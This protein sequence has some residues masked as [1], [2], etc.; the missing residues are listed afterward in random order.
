MVVQNY[1][2]GQGETSADKLTQITDKLRRAY[3]C[4][5]ERSLV[6]KKALDILSTWQIFD[7]DS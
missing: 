2:F 6:K 7:S 3:F 1:S 4:N 5:E